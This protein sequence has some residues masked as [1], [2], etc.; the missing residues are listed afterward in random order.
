MCDLDSTLVF[1]IIIYITCMLHDYY[2]DNDSSYQALF[3][4][5]KQLQLETMIILSH[6]QSIIK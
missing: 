1:C 2:N 4:K 5:C 3:S 6:M